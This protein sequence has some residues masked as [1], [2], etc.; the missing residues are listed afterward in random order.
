MVKCK[1]LDLDENDDCYCLGLGILT[2]FWL[3]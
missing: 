1:L 3:S 2:F